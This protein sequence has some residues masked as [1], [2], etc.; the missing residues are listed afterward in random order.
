MT[1]IRSGKVP[2][3]LVQDQQDLAGAGPNYGETAVFALSRKV[4]KRVKN[5]FSFYKPTKMVVY[6]LGKGT[7]HS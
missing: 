2:L 3:I 7:F 5:P 4:K 6:H 1:N